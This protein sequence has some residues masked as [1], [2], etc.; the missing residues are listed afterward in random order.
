[1]APRRGLLIIRRASGGVV[2]RSHWDGG[3]RLGFVL[4]G[5]QREYAVKVAKVLPAGVYIVDSWAY[6]GRKRLHVRGRFKLVGPN[7]L[8]TAAATLVSLDV[9]PHPGSPGF[10]L[11]LRNVGNVPVT[12]SAAVTLS[13]VIGKVR[14]APTA[15]QTFEGTVIEPGQVG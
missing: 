7:E 3:G 4:P 9:T 15:S 2:Q 8:P 6:Y 12:P 14:R 11:T 13:P 1:T 10:K 5:A